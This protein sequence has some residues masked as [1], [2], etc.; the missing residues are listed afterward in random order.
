MAKKN[1]KLIIGFSTPKAWYAQ[2]ASWLI[3]KI[4]GCD[5]SHTYI[6]ISSNNLEEDLYYHASGLSVKFLGECLFKEQNNIVKEFE[7]DIT[8]YRYYK[9]LDFAISQTG[10]PFSIP[11]L[12][13]IG[14]V[15]MASILG[16]KI[17]NP[18]GKKGYICTELVAHL[19][20]TV[21]GREITKDFDSIT[22]KDIKQ[23]IEK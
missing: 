19:L 6:K 16:K 9:T 13:G 7:F 1:K 10:K 17:R 2:P 15:R 3:K 11:Q 4:E 22:L 8:D 20:I 14:I 5:Y 23:L 18:F 21:Y 12:F